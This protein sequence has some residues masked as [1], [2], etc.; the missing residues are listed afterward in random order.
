MTLYEEV[1]SRPN[2]AK[3]PVNLN[4]ADTQN[5][6]INPIISATFSIVTVAVT[7]KVTG[8]QYNW[9]PSSGWGSNGAPYVTPGANNLQVAVAVNNHG[10]YTETATL[11]VT[12]SSGN[13]QTVS[14][15][16]LGYTTM[17]LPIVTLNMPATSLTLTLAVTP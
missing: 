1:F 11:T 5:I 2:G 13:A 9:S 7:D 14:G 15:G 17:A 6:T 10:S 16:I 4:F 8:V 12:P 3:F